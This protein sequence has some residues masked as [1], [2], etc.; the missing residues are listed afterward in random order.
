MSNFPLQLPHSAVVVVNWPLIGW[1]SDQVKH[2][3]ATNIAGIGTLHATLAVTLNFV[4]GG[5][6]CQEQEVISVQCVYC[7]QC[8]F[9]RM[10][11]QSV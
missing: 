9:M 8:A 1:S 4:A 2:R 10:T 5:L 3:D 11:G 7:K 6:Y